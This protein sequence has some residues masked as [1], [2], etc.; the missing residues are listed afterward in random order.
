M[1]YRTVTVHLPESLLCAAEAM[2]HGEAISV[3]QLVRQ[4]LAGKV[5]HDAQADQAHLH[6]VL[7]LKGRLTG[8]FTA[9]RSWS[10]LQ[11]R[12]RAKGYLLIEAGGGLTLATAGDETA[13]CRAS[14]LG[15]DIATLIRKFGTGFPGARHAWLSDRLHTGDDEADDDF[16]VID[17]SDG[18]AGRHPSA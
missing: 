6:R 15:F 17:W 9:A 4:A 2:A 14:E 13:L 11:S 10:D 7:S 18:H 12:L 8:E 5:G 3:A 16:D 1:G